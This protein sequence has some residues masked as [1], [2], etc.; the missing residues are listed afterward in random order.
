MYHESLMYSTISQ[1]NPQQQPST[2][3]K[4]DFSPILP[5]LPSTNAVQIICLRFPRKRGFFILIDILFGGLSFLSILCPC[6]KYSSTGCDVVARPLSALDSPLISISHSLISIAVSL[7]RYDS[8]SHPI[9]HP[10]GGMCSEMLSIGPSES[11]SISHEMPSY[12]SV[13]G[14]SYPRGT[15]NSS[16]RGMIRSVSISRSLSRR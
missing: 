13:V 15:K 9:S 10:W 5:I 1:G 6:P 4:I 8:P 11:Y 3:K 2:S 14:L 12:H 7:D 16:H